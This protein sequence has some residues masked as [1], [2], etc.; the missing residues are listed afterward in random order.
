MMWLLGAPF[1]VYTPARAK[2]L[3][4]PTHFQGVSPMIDYEDGAAAIAWL[5][6]AFGFEETMRIVSPLGDGSTIRG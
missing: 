4:M 5:T 1:L 6:Q 2:S 3:F